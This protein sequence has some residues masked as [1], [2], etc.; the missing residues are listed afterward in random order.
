[1]NKELHTPFKTTTVHTHD[2]CVCVGACPAP[3]TKD[4]MEGVFDARL[5]FSLKECQANRCEIILI[6][7][8]KIF[9]FKGP[10]LQTNTVTRITR[11]CKYDQCF[12]RVWRLMQA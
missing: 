5:P 3:P 1:M 11:W 9:R 12:V 10:L 6:L 8:V 7:L 4:I 2:V